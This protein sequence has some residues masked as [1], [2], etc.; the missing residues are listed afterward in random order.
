MIKKQ[1][2][3]VIKL[4]K[5]PQGGATTVKPRDVVRAR[6]TIYGHEEMSDKEFKFFKKWLTN[7]VPETAKNKRGELSKVF[8]QTLYKQD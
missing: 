6:L 5:K 7:V 8:R 2:V 1:K 3:E 4:Y